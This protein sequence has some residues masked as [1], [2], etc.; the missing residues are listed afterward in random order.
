[1][2]PI[3]SSV[4]AAMAAMI[5]TSKMLSPCCVLAKTLAKIRMVSPG[6]RN[7]GTLEK[8]SDKYGPVAIMGE[9]II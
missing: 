7:P 2:N 8:D 9:E 4:T 3:L 6:Q 5:A 1:M